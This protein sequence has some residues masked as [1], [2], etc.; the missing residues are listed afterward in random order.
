MD[1]SYE[2]RAGGSVVAMVKGD[3][4]LN[5][6]PVLRRGL[7]ARLDGVPAGSA[8]VLGLAGVT[9]MDSSG[10]AVLIETL[11]RSRHRGAR[12]ALAAASPA[13]RMVIEL[14]RLER[15]FPIVDDVEAALGGGT[16]AEGRAGDGRTS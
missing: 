13:V 3:V 10:V 6:S 1:V 15:I 8:L 14:A 2:S 5:T 11:Q 7:L 4:D 12:L 16:A 9:Y